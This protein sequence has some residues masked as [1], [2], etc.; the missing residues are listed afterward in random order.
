LDDSVDASFV[1][2]D[3][4]PPRRPVTPVASEDQQRGG[5]MSDMSF[6]VVVIGGGQAGLAM[7]YHLAQRGLRFVILEAGDR[8]GDAWRMRWDGLRLF[9][10]ARYDGLPGMPFPAPSLALPTKDEVADYL[11]SYAA[12]KELPVR[13]RVQVDGLWRNETDDGYLIAVGDRDFEAAQVVVATGAYHHPRVPDFAGELDPRIR[14]IHSSAF[15]RPSQLLDG[16]V[17]VVGASNSGA[18][19]AL[20]AAQEHRTSLAGPNKGK[21]P[22]R[23]GSRLAHLFDP[24]FWFFI[25]RVATL[26]TP[27]GRKALPFVRDHGGPLE[28]VWPADLAAAGVERLNARAVGAHEGMPVL[29]D[30]RVVDVANVIWATGFRPDFGWIHLPVIGD[31]GW[32]HQAR[33]V[34][35][36]APGLYFVGLPFLFAAASP[37][38]GG[39]GRDAEFVAREI[40][41]R[42]RQSSPSVSRGTVPIPRNRVPDEVAG[43]G[44]T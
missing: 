2:R 41:S 4:R 12:A 39:V 23:L 20:I 27:I 1:A 22:F 25:N 44:A 6:D 7:G 37:L 11:E 17:L 19:I 33:G 26:A 14:Q 31:D 36:I 30:G 3:Y 29:E 15:R 16:A 42:A 40:A 13:T 10:S 32:P 43:T 34:V 21:M 9:T 38:L 35:P 28:R 24:V 18:E 5:E 8:I